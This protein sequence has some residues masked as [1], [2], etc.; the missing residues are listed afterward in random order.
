MRF[1]NKRRIAAVLVTGT[2]AALAV[3]GAAF[4]GT[5]ST[6][7]SSPCSSVISASSGGGMGYARLKYTAHRATTRK[8]IIE[9]A[10]STANSFQTC[11]Q[12]NA[13]LP[14]RITVTQQ[15]QFHGSSLSC[16]GGINASFPRSAGISFSCTGSGSTVTETL[17]TTCAIRE[18]QCLIDQGYMEIIAPSGSS[19]ANYV[20]AKTGVVVRNSTG[21]AVSW[22]TAFI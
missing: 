3:P 22:S 5:W 11:A 21:N 17:S 4:A 1:L 8:Y 14:Y 18:A 10:R 15:F 19:F 6:S 20:L 16:T 13:V 7:K 9:A 12:G 2:L